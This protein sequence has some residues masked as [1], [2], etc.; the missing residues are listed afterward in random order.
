MESHSLPV[1]SDT[2]RE[3]SRISSISTYLHIIY[4]FRS[5]TSHISAAVQHVHSTHD[6]HTAADTS[7]PS[8]P[9]WHHQHQPLLSRGRALH[10]A[11]GRA[12]GQQRIVDTLMN[13]QYL[14]C[15]LYTTFFMLKTPPQLRTSDS[16]C[17]LPA[18]K[19]TNCRYFRQL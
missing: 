3:Q 9:M 17:P 7:R 14:W 19:S 12:G 1:A 6:T 16:A 15:L 5:H 18:R 2:R 8:Q 13:T 10:Q 4:L 11:G